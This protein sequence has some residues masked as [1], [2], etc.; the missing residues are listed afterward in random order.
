MPTIILNVVTENTREQKDTG[1]C[2]GSI[3]TRV[4]FILIGVREKTQYKG[5]T[6]KETIG[7]GHM[8]PAA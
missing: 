7:N 3:L 6:R 8:R 4:L 2:S 1:G 5:G